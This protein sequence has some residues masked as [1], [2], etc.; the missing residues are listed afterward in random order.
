LRILA[1]SSCPLDPLLGSGKT[2][3]RWSQ[4]LRALG[5]EVDMLEPR[6]FEWWHG[7][8]RALRFRQ[9]LGAVGAIRARLRRRA[10]DLIEFFGGEFGIATRLLSREK[11]RPLMV[12]HTDGFELLASERLQQYDPPH[13]LA[14]RLHRWYAHHTHDRLS[15]AAFVHADAFVTGCELDLQSVLRLELFP[16][17]RTAVVSP[18]LDDEYLAAPPQPRAQPR[19][20]F[21]GSWIA[22]K[23]VRNLVAVMNEVLHARAEV[24]LDLYGTACPAETVF[25]QFPAALRGRV[26]VHGRLSNQ[27]IAEGL[28]RAHVFFFPSQYEGFGMALAEAM[29]CGCAPVT[30]PT[31]FG[32]ELRDGS[33]ALLC[34]FDDRKAMLRAVLALLD[35]HGLRERIAHAAQQRARALRWQDQVAK[36]ESLYRSW[37]SR[38]PR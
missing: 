13:T 5:H 21:I 27:Q 3:L 26:Q 16:R 19:V 20:A 8:R 10:Y 33:E 25:A 30:T 6:D 15:R 23:G 14:L 34:A 35:D 22:R 7:A 11:T 37:L 28:S 29:A 31:G 9:A 18:G 38:S 2:R 32:A 24:R 12:A 36:L 4:G 1:L 17:E